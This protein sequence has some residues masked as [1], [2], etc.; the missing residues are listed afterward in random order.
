M[1]RLGIVVVLV[2]T[3]GLALAGCKKAEEPAT[4]E[5]MRRPLTLPKEISIP[6]VQ[7]PQVPAVEQ[8]PIQAPA[9]QEALPTEPPAAPAVEQP[10]VPQL[11]EGIV[12]K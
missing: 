3:V 11:P 6:P 10:V 7:V 12:P 9:L 2:V 4:Q 5:P 1:G 8:L